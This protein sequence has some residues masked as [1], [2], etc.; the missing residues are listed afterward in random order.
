VQSMSLPIVNMLCHKCRDIHFK[1]IE[2]CP[3]VKLYADDPRNGYF[4]E[5]P[6]LFYLHSTDRICLKNSADA[7]CHFC[8]M[9]YYRLFQRTHPVRG[10]YRLYPSIGADQIVLLLQ[11]KIRTYLSSPLS[12]LEDYYFGACHGD[13]RKIVECKFQYPGLF[14]HHIHDV[15]KTD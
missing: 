10:L 11:K 14:V 5:E 7:G 1:R 15:R 9:I 8:I 13:S 3:T 6:Y 4:K 2:D 12:H